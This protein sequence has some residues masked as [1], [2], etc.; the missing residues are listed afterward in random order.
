MWKL[1]VRRHQSTV[2]N[3]WTTTTTR[4]LGGLMASGSLQS[5]TISGDQM[6]MGGG[7]QVARAMLMVV[8][9]QV[10]RAKVLVAMQ[11]M[12]VVNQWTSQ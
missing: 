1:P 12:A 9:K 10:A 7:N 8:A 2:G 3:V 11:I 5:H 4:G 6:A